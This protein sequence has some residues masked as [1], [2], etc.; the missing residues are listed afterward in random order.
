[1]VVVGGMGYRLG[2]L[3]GVVFLRTIEYVVRGAAAE[4]TTLVIAAVSLL[5]VLYFREG[6]A[7]ALTLVWR[8]LYAPQDRWG[9][10]PSNPKPRPAPSSSS[11]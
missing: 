9:D 4:Y 2:P 5:V 11:S 3:L 6:L 7:H 8:R 1:M 10:G